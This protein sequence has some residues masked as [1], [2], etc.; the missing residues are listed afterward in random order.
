MAREETQ[1]VYCWQISLEGLTVYLASFRRGALRVGLSLEA[2]ADCTDYFRDLMGPGMLRADREMNASL[3]EAVEAAWHN[4][5]VS[6]PVLLAEHGTLFQR[7]VWE[8]VAGIPFGVT[9]TYGDV[10][11]MVGRPLAARA[12]GQAMG[13]NPLPLI[14]P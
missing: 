8:A 4:R 1:I 7:S 10:A 12:I 11:R 2:G 3:I 9:R 5:T 14:Y 13:R 6:R